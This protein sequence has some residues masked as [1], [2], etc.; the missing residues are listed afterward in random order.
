MGD[1]ELKAWAAGHP[2]SPQAKAVLA[3]FA[4]LDDLTHRLEEANRYVRVLA[5]AA[6]GR[7]VTPPPGPEPA[8]GE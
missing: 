5:N 3:L 7:G 8:G 6:R 4:R 1:D 2:H